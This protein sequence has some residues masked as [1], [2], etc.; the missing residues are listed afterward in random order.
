MENNNFISVIICTYNRGESLRE[1]LDSFFQQEGL[2]D[3]S[4]ELI[5]VDNNS[6][7]HT[8]ELIESYILKY[9]DVLKYFIEKRQGLSYARNRGIQESK[10]DVIAFT[11]DDVLIDKAW[12]YN[13]VDMFQK[14]DADLVGGRVLPI[15]PPNTPKW[16]KDNLDV[17]SGPIVA[18]EY[19]E[20]IR[21]Y[22]GDWSI[23]P[24]GAN[25]IF[26]KELFNKYGL[27]RTDLGVGTGTNNEDTEFCSR[28]LNNSN[29]KAFYCGKA[30]IWHPV[31]EDRMSLKYIARW[32]IASGRAEGLY[33]KL[34]SSTIY[35]FGIPRYL[36]RSFILS[37]VFLIF[38]SFSCRKF[39]ENWVE[40]FVRY[41]K[42][43]QYNKK[44]YGKN[45]HS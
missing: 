39:L 12:L 26:R 40:V 24:I 17:L 32:A 42:I 23:E 38:T 22:E 14:Y 8:R 21:R 20:E 25:M 33:N 31:L 37:I 1:T 19:G 27:F 16:V 11:D 4:Y 34:A 29:I 30:L 36:L 43:Q 18:Y 10:G 41:G 2:S 5:M 15:Y 9:G 7:D 44:F 13:L 45:Q 6:S 3:I 35:Y 28:C